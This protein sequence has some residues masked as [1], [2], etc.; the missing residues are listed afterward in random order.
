MLPFSRFGKPRLIT[1]SLMLAMTLLAGCGGPTSPASS[2]AP[3]GTPNSGS[4][5]LTVSSVLVTQAIQT[6]SPLNSVPL[7][8]Q[9][10]TAVR[11]MLGNSGNGSVAGVTGKLSVFVDATSVPLGT[12]ATPINGSI[13]TPVSPQWASE[14][15]TLNFEI[16]SPS[17][18]TASSNVRFHVDI[19]PVSGETTATDNAGEVTLSVANRTTPL[20][21]YTRIN[22]KGG[23]LPDDSFIQPGV[24]DAFVRGIYPVNDNDL[25]LYRQGLFPSL[26]WNEDT[27][28]NNMI[29]GSEGSDLLS[30]LAQCRQLI[31]NSGVGPDDRVFLYAWVRGNPISGNGLSKEGGR[32]GFGNTDPIR[33]QRSFAHELGHLI[34]IDDRYP[35]NSYHNSDTIGN[36]GWDVG[37]RLANHPSGNNVAADGRL[38]PTTFYDIMNAGRL[39]NEAYIEPYNYNAVYNNATLATSPDARKDIARVAVIQGIFDPSGERLLT[40]N[41][42]FR[43]PWPSGPTPPLPERA[44][45]RYIAVISSSNG[46]VVR[47]PFDAVVTRDDHEDQVVRGF[48]EVMVPVPGEITALSIIDT[49]TGQTVATRKPSTRA[50]VIEVTSPKQGSQLGETTTITWNAQYSVPDDQVQYQI[51]YS[52]DGGK[53]FI[54]IAV[55]VPGKA[56][57]VTVNTREIPKSSGQGLIRV[58]IGDGLNTAY[59]DV[60]DLTPAAAIY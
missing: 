25:N 21:Y 41:P 22:F 32:V 50:P 27:N 20:L 59:A 56:R 5:N 31:V 28:S 4:F 16:P 47:V 38:K 48:F 30:F 57:S 44:K 39:T 58:F 42:V 33:G 49:Q 17:G 8:A 46:E 9:R 10:S 34:G 2:C 26:P 52:R 45:A 51:A 14:C 12:H 54:P 53:S 18:I 13:S 1:V 43:Y 35:Q 6:I 7:V 23:G 55:N 3:S 37:G 29:D 19:T 40:L 24:G 15:D 60:A 36:V 11:V